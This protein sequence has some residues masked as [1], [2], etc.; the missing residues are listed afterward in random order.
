MADATSLSGVMAMGIIGV[1]I[2]LILGFLIYVIVLWKFTEWIGYKKPITTAILVT[3]LAILFTLL[4]SWVPYVGWLIAFLLILL[5]IK[6]AYDMKGLMGWLIALLIDFAVGLITIIILIPLYLFLFAFIIGASISWVVAAIGIIAFLL[7]FIVVISYI[8]R[9]H[10]KQGGR[11][12]MKSDTKRVG[13][14]YG[15]SKSYY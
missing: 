14:G 13:G 5:T 7:V 3:I 8:Y 4:L 12:R 10:K 1:A 11:K 15:K 9:K 2:L 6:I